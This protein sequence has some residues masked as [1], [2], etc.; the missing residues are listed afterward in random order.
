MCCL[1]TA[2]CRWGVVC[3]PCNSRDPITGFPC[4][5]GWTASISK[6]TFD[7]EQPFP[8]NCIAESVRWAGICAKGETIGPVQRLNCVLDLIG[9]GRLIRW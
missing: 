4:V 6:A 9:E 7:R 5:V 3:P 8:F 2:V 1:P